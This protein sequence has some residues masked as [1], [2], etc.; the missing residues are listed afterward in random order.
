MKVPEDEWLSATR[1]F[2]ETQ[3]LPVD[4]PVAAAVKRFAPKLSLREDE[5]CLGDQKL[6]F[7]HEDGLRAPYLEP[8]FR[9]DLLNRLYKEFSHLGYPGL[10][11]VLRPRAWWP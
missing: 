10:I 5:G 2:L 7:A 4:P 3:E 11:D 9:G 6:I 1:Q 8:I